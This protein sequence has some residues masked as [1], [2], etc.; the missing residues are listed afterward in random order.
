M[1]PGVTRTRFHYI[2]MQEAA[3]AQSIPPITYEAWLFPSRRFP[4]G[5]F[6]GEVAV[7]VVS[8]LSVRAVKSLQV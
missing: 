2:N 3:R 5:V 4:L 8:T 6:F 7:S 1:L